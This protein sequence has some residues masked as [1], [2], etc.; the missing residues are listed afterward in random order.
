MDFDHGRRIM[1]WVRGNPDKQALVVA[2]AN[3]SADRTPGNKYVMR[4]W[5]S[6]PEGKKWREVVE[7][8]SVP[9]DSVGREPLSRWNAKAYEMY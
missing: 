4:N 2:V 6:T 7:N 1:A 8:Q 9:A 3:L 5:P